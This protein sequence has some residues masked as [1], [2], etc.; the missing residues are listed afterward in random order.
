VPVDKQFIKA[1][2]SNYLR[3]YIGGDEGVTPL[4]L[5]AGLGRAEFIRALLDAGANKNLHTKKHKMLALYF[6]A[7]TSKPQ[8]VQMLLGPRPEP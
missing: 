3:D 6:A 1:V 5:A 4:M 8:C 2:A 7:R